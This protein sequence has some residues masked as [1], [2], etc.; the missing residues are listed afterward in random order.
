MSG[1]TPGGPIQTGSVTPKEPVPTNS[2]SGGGGSSST[3]GEV[4][5]YLSSV[6]SVEK[7]G[8]AAGGITPSSVAS[9]ASAS[10]SAATSKGAAIRDVGGSKVRSL[11]ALVMFVGIGVF[12]L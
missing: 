8:T 7:S 11:G 1:I 10:S 9:S 6:I 2:A 3:N 12:V 5:G 4:S